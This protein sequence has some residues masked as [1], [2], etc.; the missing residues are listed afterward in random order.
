MDK[1]F[2]DF[3]DEKKISVIKEK[4]RQ[5][6]LED[7]FQYLSEKYETVKMTASNEFGV[8]VGSAP[9]ADGFAHDVV[10]TIK[11]STRYW[12]EKDGKRPIHAYDLDK[13]ADAYLAEVNAKGS[14]IK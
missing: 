4:A 7:I 6:I 10:V 12:Y 9:D 1:I 8:V 5:L 11:C 3:M 14:Y 13:E 2:M